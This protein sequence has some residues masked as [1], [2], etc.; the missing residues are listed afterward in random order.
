MDN[1]PVAGVARRGLSKTAD[2]TAGSLPSMLG[3]E[4]LYPQSM[5]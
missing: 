1:K 5:I 3:A 4:R 2:M